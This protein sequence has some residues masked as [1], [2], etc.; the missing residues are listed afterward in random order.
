MDI[1][2]MHI[3]KSMLKNGWFFIAAALFLLFA[4]V[5]YFRHQIP[6]ISYEADAIGYMARAES[7]WLTAHPFHGP[8]YSWAIKIMMFS[9]VDAFSAGKMISILSTL[10]LI[11]CSWML[12]DR[13]PLGFFIPFILVINPVLLSHSVLV[14]SDMMAAALFMAVILLLGKYPESGIA[15]LF[16]GVT[17][18]LAYLTRSLYLFILLLPLLEWF[19]KTKPSSKIKHLSFFYIGFLV[20]ALP[21]SLY[22]FI[23]KGSPFWNLNY[24]NILFKMEGLDQ[25]WREFP[26]FDDNASLSMV[27]S[28]PE[29]F[30]KGWLKTL[31]ALPKNIFK[32]FPHVGV[33]SALAVWFWIAD[34]DRKKF[35]FILGLAIYSILIALV[36]I[37]DRF[38]LVYLPLVAVL[39]K[40][41]VVKTPKHLRFDASFKSAPSRLI[42]AL[43]LQTLIMAMIFCITLALSLHNVPAFF[44]D[45]PTEFKQA[46]EWIE[47]QPQQPG[48]IMSAKPHIAYFSGAAYKSFRS[49]HLHMLSMQELV[50][51]LNSIEPDYFIYDERYSLQAYPNLK[52]LLTPEKPEIP[53]SFSAVHVI[54]G[55]KKLVIYRLESN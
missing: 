23:E 24:L 25:G 49:S 39:L 13:K 7:S 52:S 33:L 26:Y 14:L 1:K 12:L 51:L 10:L 8:A 47:K 9:G 36:W 40:E 21:W 42:A 27:L 35:F 29:L 53:E 4:S 15:M 18:A 6:L 38:L 44:N 54:P 37:T 20:T 2:S 55:P 5:L 48:T 43:P 28:Q 3:D 19:F 45:E 32:L 41:A 46:A 11:T 34:I 22:L 31:F 50:N 30:L 17:G 16:A